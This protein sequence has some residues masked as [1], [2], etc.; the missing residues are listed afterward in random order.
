MSACCFNGKKTW[1]FSETSHMYLG[2][3]KVISLGVIHW[4]NWTPYDSMWRAGNGFRLEIT[5]GWLFVLIQWASLVVQPVKNPPA[6]WEI[7]VQSLGWEDGRAWMKKMAW[8]PTP[9]VLSGVSLWTEEP[10]GL[11]SKGSQRVGHDWV[12]K[13]TVGLSLVIL[14]VEKCFRN[15]VT[16]RDIWVPLW[17]GNYSVYYSIYKISCHWKKWASPLSCWLCEGW[18]WW[19]KSRRAVR[20]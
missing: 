6:R 17:K 14:V 12:T 7:W 8:Q 10:G 5:P 19:I 18:K 15:S 9:V 13:H 20:D 2:P 16:T 1:K 4:W 11:Q 3:E